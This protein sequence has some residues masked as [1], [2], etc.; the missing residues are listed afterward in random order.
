M[1]VPSVSGAINSTEIIVVWSGGTHFVRYVVSP[2]IL[3]PLAN[4]REYFLVQ[5]HEPVFLI[6]HF[7]IKAAPGS[8]F[9]PSAMVM[10]LMYVELSQGVG[11]EIGNEKY[12][13]DSCN[14]FMFSTA[15]IKLVLEITFR[16]S[17]GIE[18]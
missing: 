3:S 1:Y 4:W 7:L 15:V 9:V 12:A 17:A 13:V 5:A 14:G 11:D 2:D 10:S 8:I 6:F 16:G 18:F